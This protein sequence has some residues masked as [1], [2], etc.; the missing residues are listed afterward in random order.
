MT[1]SGAA[2]T[3]KTNKAKRTVLIIV[4]AVLALAL[5][6]LVASVLILGN[7][8]NVADAASIPSSPSPTP[9]PS[10]LTP[11]EALLAGSSDP[12]ACAISFI[13]DTASS[14]EL[15]P[16]LQ[17]TGTLYTGLPIPK[18]EGQIFAGWYETAEGAN[19]LDRA[20]RIGGGAL[21][22][23][24]QQQRTLYGAWVTPE[25]FE[26][27]NTSVP[28]LMYHQFTEKPEGEDHWLASNYAYIGDF[29]DHMAYLNEENFYLPT[30]DE[31]SAF[32][33]R[34]LYLPQQSAIVTDDDADQSW[35][36]L[37]VPEVHKNGILTTSF[38]VT[39]YRQDPAP[40]PY[41]LRRSHSH[42][43]HEA[44]ANG[45][46]RIV[47]WSVDEITADLKASIAVVDGVSEVFCYPF[48]HYNDTAKAALS[49]N[50]F[51]I[52][53]TTEYGYVTPGMD[54]L[55]LPRVRINHGYGVETFKNLVG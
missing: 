51:E 27:E 9:E 8:Q 33:D 46:G 35:F 54:K 16:Q 32:I 4:I 12:N 50:G 24:E 2:F 42:D 26:A 36:D 31:L 48:G 21:T 52:A 38:M 11:A 13:L 18:R 47:N 6:A 34:E 15:E 55:E 41:V 17:S 3:T 14:D 5:A 45:Q 20:S 39:K 28:I 19:A 53:V 30:W 1:G 23:C 29:A 10:P 7:K 49:A 43:M 44:G 37:A 25:Q 22:E 40:S